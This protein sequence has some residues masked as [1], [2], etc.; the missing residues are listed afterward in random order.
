MQKQGT[1]VTCKHLYETRAESL[2]GV[3]FFICESGLQLIASVVFSPGLMVALAGPNQPS[4]FDVLG[5][6]S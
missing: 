1:A 5:G 6:R 4:L 2:K 3:G